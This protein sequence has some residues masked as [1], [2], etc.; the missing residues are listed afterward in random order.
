MTEPVVGIIGAGVVGRRILRRFTTLVPDATLIEID[1]RRQDIGAIDQRIDLV[2]L[3]QP[4]PHHPSARRLLERGIDVVSIGDGVDDVRALFDLEAVA[5]R[6]DATLVVGAGMSSGLVALL[7][8][9]LA[10][11]CSSIDEVHVHVH[12]TA[13]PSCARQHHHALAGTSTNMLD[14]REISTRAGTGRQLAFFPE[15]VG[16]YDCYHAEMAAPL[17][18]RRAFPEVERIQAR[19]SANRRDRLTSRLPM[20]TRPHSEGGVGALRVEV[21]GT[22]DRGGR[23]THVAGIA[24]LV[25]T[26]A[27]ATAAAFAGLLLADERAPGLVVPGGEDVPTTDLLRSIERLG[28]RLQLFTGVPSA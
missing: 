4:G 26:A 20:L 1:T 3:A 18:I 27:A 14:G 8:R 5:R 16:A 24:E 23:V 9:Q 25:G 19:M 17:V 2:I 21:R 10:G 7:A 15:P 11:S 22:D 12:G 6:G 28:V 13:G